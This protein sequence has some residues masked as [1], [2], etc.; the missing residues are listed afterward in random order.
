M[1]PR[2]VVKPHPVNV[3][4]RFVVR[5]HPW[6]WQHALTEITLAPWHRL[7]R[8]LFVVYPYCRL[9]CLLPV[10]ICLVFGFHASMV[11]CVPA[12]CRRSVWGR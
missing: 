12:Q 8:C 6:E 1:G 2:F 3:G 7:K 9:C 5:K 4:R 11:T 10:A